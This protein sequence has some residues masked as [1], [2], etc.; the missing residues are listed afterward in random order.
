LP[1]SHSTHFSALYVELYVP[2]RHASQCHRSSKC[3]LVYEVR[4]F[5]GVH[6]GVGAAVGAAV[7]FVS[8]A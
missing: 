5:P 2:G 3:S 1:S 7:V 4:Q 6:A 8:T